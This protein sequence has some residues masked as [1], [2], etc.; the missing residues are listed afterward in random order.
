MSEDWSEDTTDSLWRFCDELDISRSERFG[1]D[2][3][4]FLRVRVLT[5][6]L[7]SMG[8]SVEGIGP[9]PDGSGSGCW[10]EFYGHKS[11]YRVNVD[12]SRTPVEIALASC[13]LD[14]PEYWAAR[15]LG[16]DTAGC[17]YYLFLKIVNSE[18]IGFGGSADMFRLP[19]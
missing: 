5:N 8:L 6:I 2:D 11:L 16:Q 14:A 3:S 4:V 19:G 10:I 9:L 7:T 12:S 18:E 13:G 15:F 1:L 17:W